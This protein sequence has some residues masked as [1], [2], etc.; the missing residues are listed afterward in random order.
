MI[1]TLAITVSPVGAKTSLSSRLL[2]YQKVFEY[3]PAR[4]VTPSAMK[5]QWM[6]LIA[7]GAVMLSSCYDPYYGS[8]YGAGP[9]PANAAE[10]VVPLVVGAALVGAILS[11]N[12]DCYRGGYYGGNYRCPPRPCW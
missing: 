1:L 7:A 11:N 8:G 5:K 3:F 10:A 2:L 9:Y 4:I 6:L 12:N